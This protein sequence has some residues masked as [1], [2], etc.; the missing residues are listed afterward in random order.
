MCVSI[1]IA[2]NRGERKGEGC[3]VGVFV[4]DGSSA[5]DQVDVQDHAS[6]RC[7]KAAAVDFVSM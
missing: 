2:C 3:T 5:C 1:N 4:V 7:T 6:Q